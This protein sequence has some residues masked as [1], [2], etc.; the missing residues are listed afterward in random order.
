ERL[1]L[2]DSHNKNALHYVAAHTG[3]LVA[4]ASIAVA[5]PELL[6]SADEDG[7]TPLHLAVIQ[8]N[9]AMVNLLLANKADVNAVDKEGHSVVH[10]ATGNMWRGGCFALG[11]GRCGANVATPDINGGSPLHYAAQMCGASYEGWPPAIA[12]GASAGSAKAVIALVKAGARVESADKF[13]KRWFNRLALVA[14]RGHTECID[15]L[16]S[17]CG[18]P[19]D[20]IDS[21]GFTALHYA[22]TLGHADATSRLLDFEADP[23]RQDRKGRTPAHCGCAKGQFET[24]KLLSAMPI[25]GYA[26]LK[27][28]CLCMRQQLL[29]EENWWSGCWSK[30]LSKSIPPVMMVVLCFT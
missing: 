17:L 24:V 6:E 28:I 13:V 29:V 11:F 4:A 2:R 15:T 21:N 10:W 12:M 8:G 14:S 26:M 22:V 27:V 1:R 30:G 19:T 3:D 18:A 20:L 5:A 23:N 25:S 9:L 7:F 16:I